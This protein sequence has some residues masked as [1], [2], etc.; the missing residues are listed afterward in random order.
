[1]FSSESDSNEY[2]QYTTFNIKKKITLN[3]PKSAAMGVFS[4]GLKKGFE[5]TEV[6]EPSVFEPRK[7]YFVYQRM[8]EE[9]AAGILS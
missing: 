8:P 7:V 6:N 5:T 4:K 1:M 2:T 9:G 3:H